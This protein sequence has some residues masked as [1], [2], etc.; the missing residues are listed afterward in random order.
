VDLTA[1]HAE[2]LLTKL[3]HFAGDLDSEERTLLGAL[4]APAF[5][6]AFRPD[7]EGFA[8]GEDGTGPLP[9]VLGE[10]L[11]AHPDAMPALG[12]DAT[13]RLGGT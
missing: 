4:V 7:V 1:Q 2:Q 8:F 9:E 10:A 13:E 12:L 3:L 5:A 6:R 11:R